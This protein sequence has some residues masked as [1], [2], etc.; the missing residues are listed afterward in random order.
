MSAMRHRLFTILTMLSLLLCIAAVAMWVRSLSVRDAFPESLHGSGYSIRSWDGR[1]FIVHFTTA[2]SP[3]L[4]VSVKTPSIAGGNPHNPDAKSTRARSAVSG[5]QQR[6]SSVLVLP[7]ITL[8]AGSIHNGF[9]FS[10][11]TVS[12]SGLPSGPF[13]VSIVS[14][15]YR[16]I[17]A[18]SLLIPIGWCIRLGLRRRVDPNRC[19]R[20]GY[21]LTGNT[22][23]RCPECGIA[24]K[25]ITDS[26]G[27]CALNPA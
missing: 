14:I 11:A 9:G 1:I 5:S 16:S 3:G 6:Y 13:T 22:S 25:G 21:N 7:R 18:L 24:I 23:G 27:D 15:P 26:T 8:P 10:R 19:R 2:N 17:C 4:F 12:M 20:C